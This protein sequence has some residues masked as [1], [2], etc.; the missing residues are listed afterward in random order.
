VLLAAF[1]GANTIGVRSPHAV[2]TARLPPAEL[3]PP[4]GQRPPRPPWCGECDERTRM[5]G[6][7]SDAPNPCPRCKP[8]ACTQQDGPSPDSP[9]RLHRGHAQH[10]VTGF[11]GEAIG[12]AAACAG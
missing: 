5:V 6:F 7:Y 10:G 11:V 9:R 12:R 8:T 2:L 1:A 4:P 3:P